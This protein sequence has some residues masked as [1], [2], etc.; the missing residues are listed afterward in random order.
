MD[1]LKHLELTF[2]FNGITAVQEKESRSGLIVVCLPKS[3]DPAPVHQQCISINNGGAMQF[4]RDNPDF[5]VAHALTTN[6]LDFDWDHIHPRAMECFRAYLPSTPFKFGRKSKPDSHWIYQ[7]HTPFSTNR[8]TFHHIIKWLDTAFMFEGEKQKVEIR[9]RNLNDNE[10]LK[11]PVSQ[12]VYALAPGSVH[13]SGEL[14]TWQDSFNLEVTPTVF[15]ASYI[16]KRCV[17]AAI[18]AMIIHGWTEGSRQHMAMAL[19]GTFYKLTR[20]NEGVPDVALDAKKSV[21]EQ[22]NEALAKED[23]ITFTRDDWEEMIK[24]MCELTKDDESSDR[25]RAFIGSW[26]KSFDVD[27]KV[28]AMPTLRRYLKKEWTTNIEESLVTLI[29]GYTGKLSVPALIDRFFIWQGPAVVLDSER[30]GLGKHWMYT[31][32]ELKLNFAAQTVRWNGK[33]I[34]IYKFV[35]NS[36]MCRYVDGLGYEPPLDINDDTFVEDNR[37]IFRNGDV[38]LNMFYPYNVSLGD[39]EVELRDARTFLEYITQLVPSAEEAVFLLTFIKN[40]LI[41]PRVR[42][43][44]YLVMVGNQGAGKSFLFEHFIEPII[45]RH[46]M[47]TSDDIDTFFDKHNALNGGKL[48]YLFE[49]AT[50]KDSKRN[51]GSK[52]KHLVTG[53]TIRVEPKYRDAYELENYGRVVVLSNDKDTPVA[54][55]ASVDERRAVVIH[56]TDKLV[57]KLEYFKK[58]KKWADD[59]LHV[60]LGMF[61]R[62]HKSPEFRDQILTKVSMDLGAEYDPNTYDE[63]TILSRA[64]KTKAK[65]DIQARI[66]DFIEPEVSW[67]ISGLV[68]GYP[69]NPKNQ[70]HYY[71]CYHS[72]A[73]PKL[74][75]E[76]VDEET[77]DTS[78]WPDTI[79]LEVLSADFSETLGPRV[80]RNLKHKKALQLFGDGFIPLGRKRVEVVENGVATIR[81]FTLYSMPPKQDII[82][83]L[84]KTYGTLIEDAIQQIEALEG[85]E[86]E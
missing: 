10:F 13:S 28:T 31:E 58:L 25:V 7:L 81:Q 16:F 64:L 17:L 20:G 45:G 70:R 71:D 34:P 9:S 21:M 44:V 67:I 26:E 23:L 83:H 4:L 27:N 79:R 5:N 37:F 48:L 22:A 75:L 54:L 78:V 80:K 6:Q 32:N 59:N 84:V 56:V 68:R 18:T 42:P 74:G 39:K 29:S 36:G 85:K 19:G 30:R 40:L 15:D 8:D 50:T 82:K 1:R 66:L 76:A 65:T 49:E 11:R 24:V 2:Q 3:K 35:Y 69:I 57:G 62:M 38:Y 12:N 60:V 53:Q 43:R 14:I 86:I 46:N 33:H 73:T 51:I 41:Q 63:A 52:I 77:I 61:A 47:T 55:D 72:K